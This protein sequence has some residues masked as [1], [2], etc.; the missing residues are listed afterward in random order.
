[1][2]N[3]GV[4]ESRIQNIGIQKMWNENEEKYKTRGEK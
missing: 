2:I 1:M 3:V 4:G